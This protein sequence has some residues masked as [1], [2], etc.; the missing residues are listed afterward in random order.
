VP[1]EPSRM[2]VESRIRT[3]AAEVEARLRERLR[4]HPL[5]AARLDEAVRYSL[6]GGGKRL[7]PILCLWTHDALRKDR[8]TAVWAAAL[9]LEMLHTY[10]LIH[11]DLPAMDDDDLRRGQPSSHVQFDEATAILAGDALQA[12]AFLVLAELPPSPGLALT[13]LL[14]EAAG[15]RGMVAGQQLD[16]ETADPRASSSAE[17]PS[18]L[19]ERIHRLKT[20]RLLGAAVA[21]GVVSAGATGSIVEQAQGAGEELGLAF[22]IADDVLDETASGDR[23]GK[24]PGKDRAQ[25]KRTAVSVLGVTA[26]RSAA[27]EHLEQALRRLRACGIASPP[28]DELATFLVRRDR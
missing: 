9:A 7:R 19:V 5:A 18:D 25:G 12:E 13:A 17:P 22:Q 8:G 15:G 10:S 11:D 20:G 27:E 28:L 14:A 4:A 16:L 3:D 26:A 1:H 23:L 21:M 2:N 6:L 24:S